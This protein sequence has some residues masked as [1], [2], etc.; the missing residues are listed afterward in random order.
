MA[1]FSFEELSGGAAPSTVKKEFSFEELAPTQQAAPARAKEFSFEEL[2]TAEVP[3]GPSPS[4]GDQVTSA[5][6]G[7]VSGAKGYFGSQLQGV[8]GMQAD[9]PAY[10][11][12]Q[13]PLDQAMRGEDQAFETYNQGPQGVPLPTKEHPLYQAGEAIQDFGK[14]ALAPAP[15][16]Q[17]AADLGSGAGSLGAVIASSL[18][19]PAATFLGTFAAGQG[20]AAER[21]VQA[22]AT[23]EQVAN[24]SRLGSIAGA[25]DVVDMLL[26]SL[27][28][29]GK[30]AGFI[31][32]VGAKVIIGAAAEGG[33]EGV[34]QLIQN[35]IAKGIYKPDQDIVEGVAYNALIG[36]IVG[37]AA[38][39]LLDRSDPGKPP[40][41]AEVGF[42]YE[43]LV[44]TPIPTPAPPDAT[45][46][47]EAVQPQM[48]PEQMV[49]LDPSKMVPISPFEQLLATPP[50]TPTEQFVIDKAPISANNSDMQVEAAV[51]LGATNQGMPLA[52]SRLEEQPKSDEELLAAIDE[53]LNAPEPAP[54]KKVIPI[55]QAPLGLDISSLKLVG[56]PKGSNPGGTYEDASGQQYYIKMG[57]S[58]AHVTNEKVAAALYQLVGAPTLE[59]VEAG[60]SHIATKLVTLGAMNANE[61]T[62]SELQKARKD[63]ITHAWLANWDAVG[64][65]GDNIGTVN[66]VPINL[67]LGGALEYRAQG[68]PK[69]EKFGFKVGELKSLLDPSIN[70]DAAKFFGGMTFT[71]LVMSASAVITLTD[72]QIIG[73]VIEAKGN[74][75]LAYK[76]IARRDD[77][78]K[79]LKNAA[80]LPA[81]ATPDQ[82]SEGLIT[83]KESTPVVETLEEFDPIGETSPPPTTALKAI[84]YKNDQLVALA[85]AKTPEE[86]KEIIAHNKK[87]SA[88]YKADAKGS[89]YPM[90]VAMNAK[91]WTLYH[92]SHTSKEFEKFKDPLTKSSEKG[93]FFTPSVKF[94][95]NFSGGGKVYK[96]RVT[97]GKT[98]MVDLAKELT[99]KSFQKEV[100]KSNPHSDPSYIKDLAKTT[101]QKIALAKKEKA[102]FY[103]KYG[104]PKLLDAPKT[105]YDWGGIHAAIEIAR[106]EGYDTIVL[107]NIN[108][109]GGHDQIVVLNPNR[110]FNLETKKMMFRLANGGG[111]KYNINKLTPQAELLKE[112]LQNDTILA[113]QE[114]KRS[115]EN[116]KIVKEAV[117][118]VAGAEVANRTSTPGKIQA[119]PGMFNDDWGVP[120]TG[121]V[122]GYYDFDAQKKNAFPLIAVAVARPMEN[123][124]STA[125][126]EGW[127]A[128]EGTLTR[129]EVAI[130]RAETEALRAFVTKNNPEGAELYSK[131]QPEEIWAEAAAFYST[132]QTL[133]RVQ[134][135]NGPAAS[136]FQKIMALLDTIR[137]VVGQYGFSRSGDIFQSFYNGEMASRR[138]GLPGDMLERWWANEGGYA[139]EHAAASEELEANSRANVAAMQKVDPGITHV[140]AQLETLAMHRGAKKLFSMTHGAVPPPQVQQALAG[141]DAMAWRHKWFWGLTRLVDLNPRFT[142]L[143]KYFGLTNSMRVDTAKIHD[144]GQSIA[145][146]WQRL[147]K[148]SDNLAQ[149]I[150]FI[151]NMNYRTP[152]EVQQGIE[153]HPTQAEFQAAVSRFGVANN[154]LSVFNKTK[155]FFEGAL[156]LSSQNAI[157]EANRIISDP[158]ARMNK[159]LAIQAQEANLLKRPYFPFLRFGKHYV[160]IRDSAGNVL[161]F[162]TFER[163]GLKSAEMVQLAAEKFYKS[164]LTPG[165]TITHGILPDTAEPF[166]GLPPALLESIKQDLAAMPN[167]AGQQPG[168]T[169]NQLAALE[170]LQFAA[171][172]ASSF[173][174]RFQNKDYV[175]GYSEDFLRSFSRYSFQFGRYFSRV[176][177]GWALREQVQAAKAMSK[178]G[179]DNKLGEIASY[180]DDHLYNTIL[181]SKQDHNFLK[182]FAFIWFLGYSVAAA[183]TN[184]TQVPFLTMPFLSSRFGGVGVGNLRATGAL[185]KSLTQV[186]NFYKKGSYSPLPGVNQSF[187]MKAL[188]YGVETG[189]ISETQAAEL[190]AMSQGSTLLGLGNNKIRRGMQKANELGAFM[191]EMAEQ[192]NRRVTYRAALSLAMQHPNA[193]GVT[194][195]VEKYK[196]EYNQ[197]VQSGFNTAE[198]GAIIAA[199][200]ATEQTQ[201]VYSKENRPRIMRGKTMGT[202]L[203]FQTYT[204][205]LLQFLGANKSS[206]LP[207]Y[208]ILS[209]AAYGLMG[210]PGSDDVMDIAEWLARK[211]FGKDFSVKR[212][213]QEYL[214]ELAGDKADVMLHGLARRGFGLPALVDLLGEKPGRGL[215]APLFDGSMPTGQYGLG[216]GHSN[217]VPFPVL[218]RSR[219]GSASRLLPFEIGKLLDPLDAEKEIGRQTQ[220][221]SGAVFGLGFNIYRMLQDHNTSWTDFKRWEM[222]AP[223]ALADASQ[224]YRAYSEERARGRGGEQGSS[225]VVNYDPRDTEQMMEV[226]ALGL[227]YTPLRQTAKWDLIM[228][229]NEATKRLEMEQ[230]AI[231]SNRY[232]AHVGGRDEEIERANQAIRDYNDRLPEWGRGYKISS[233]TLIRSIEAKERDRNAKESGIPVQNRNKPVNDYI[234]SLFPEAVVDVRKVR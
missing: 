144:K 63:F 198:A 22:G 124:L 214:V 27:G 109:G 222:A 19:S 133:K 164:K 230:K 154:A 53:V 204:L 116:A 157:A 184:L 134:I 130:L 172:P 122:A 192:F 223:R 101:A 125:Y 18:I 113:L 211:L 32:K 51:T 45:K 83:S 6:K 180:M 78:I 100:L 190:A 170:Q 216:S 141:A 167:A 56:P 202:V 29:P 181:D 229:Q 218:D 140:P 201:F 146:D 60:E 199:V 117:R 47:P 55:N 9:R 114:F 72:D 137:K 59:Y 212:K 224:G 52:K 90:H 30:V 149:F 145:K 16:T 43:E 24:A 7:F 142:P 64:L 119:E 138:E 17:F 25:T 127:H 31:G 85:E 102:E 2:T 160:L 88:K 175:P 103:Q 189:R 155:R 158:V 11:P 26:P 87:I 93:I 23:P 197:L 234:Q 104:V 215:A 1:E 107:R 205:N 112:G 34:Q 14:E 28:V 126:H 86:K 77:I 118:Q 44:S 196:D 13:S 74:V 233:D 12:G 80:E 115:Y 173:K 61:L 36:A 151:S 132:A 38:K 98:K 50:A 186:E 143:T 195:A 210:L 227:G 46:L 166:M 40:S 128:I 193:K 165:Q 67:D 232:E 96:V 220:R 120:I 89:Y 49:G 152:L 171:S 106:K 188:N 75:N 226:I 200:H 162:E 84:L 178:A 35:A 194:E 39:P 3:T 147:G 58:P 156:K 123:A 48:S 41:A 185:L 81:I 153:R 179:S 110:V 76:L 135:Y 94:A 129:E 150:D 21:A 70:P 159:I 174:H 183:T 203:T 131:A 69:G 5:G 79:Q 54:V 66:N 206:V 169:P 42:S 57:K 225:T 136:V 108:E 209:L 71:D 168:L 65:G 187:A 161:R 148:Q 219:A 4:I 207:Q 68:T 213:L 221:A 231:L 99:K 191:F 97:P 182:S 8:A 92:G 111:P 62:Y 121:E 139:A 73:T 163:K 228:A 177:Y 176:K 208:A 20:D 33:Q 82:W 217:N 95:K 15:G 105:G 10:P 37:G 91:Q